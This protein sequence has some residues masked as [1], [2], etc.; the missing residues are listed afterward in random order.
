MRRP[1]VVTIC[2]GSS[3]HLR[4][5]PE[6]IQRCTELISEHGLEHRVVLKGS[7]CISH[8]GEGMNFRIGRGRVLTAASV[9]DAVKMISDQILP[10]AKE[11]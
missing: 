9:D 2:V 7:F 11:G 5:A 8:C 6:L 1:V 4:G 10:A 3:C